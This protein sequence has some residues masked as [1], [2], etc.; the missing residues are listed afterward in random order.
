[1]FTTIED[2]I[3]FLFGV[4]SFKRVILVSCDCSEGIYYSMLQHID[5]TEMG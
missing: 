5:N 4:F 3:F 1:M 2:A